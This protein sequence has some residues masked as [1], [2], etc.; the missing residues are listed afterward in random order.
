MFSLAGIIGIILG[1]IGCLFLT[2]IFVERRKDHGA[3]LVNNSFVYSTSLAVY[4]TTWTFYGS[5]GNAAGKGLLYLTIYLG[6]TLAIIFW[7]ST[8]R[9]LV[10][11]KNKY[12]VTSLADFVSAR[13]GKSLG[14]GAIVTTLCLIG[15]IPYISLQLKGFIS[16]F[17]IMT[18]Q[19][20]S[21]QNS[22]TSDPIGPLIVCFMI[23]FTIIFGIRRLDPTERHPGMIMALTVESLLKLAAFVA[24]GVY[25]CFFKFSGPTEIFSKMSTVVAENY[26][27]MGQTTTPNFLTWMSY[28]ILAASAIMFL[29]RQFHV[30]VVEN[31]DE[32]HIKSAMWMF[33]LYLFL[34]NLFVLP[35]AMG[36]LLLGNPAKLADQF[37]LSIPLTSGLTWLTA[38]VFLGGFA[39]GTG[40]VMIETMTVSTMVSNY[41]ILPSLNS[42]K[43]LSFL[44]RHLLKFRWISAALLIITSYAYQRMVGDTYPL[45]AMG[46]I[47]FAAV[48]QFAPAIIGGLFWKKGNKTGAYIGLSS[49]FILWAFTL[50]LP[51]FVKGG[52]LPKSI[53]EQGLFGMSALRPEA[54]LG[55]SGVDSLTHAVFWSMLFNIGGYV[56]GSLFSECSRE[57]QEEADEFVNILNT[58]LDEKELVIGEKNIPCLDKYTRMEALFSQYFNNKESFSAVEKC[59]QNVDIQKEGRMTILQLSDL[60]K[61]AERMLAGSIG[62]AA[63]YQTLRLSGLINES[64]S[65]LLSKA[66]AEM[67]A[68]LKISPKELSQKINFYQERESLLTKQSDELAAV[69]RSLE[70]QVE[71]RTEEL[72]NQMRI[73]HASR[74]LSQF[75]DQLPCLQKAAEHIAR[76][77]DIQSPTVECWLLD[78]QNPV[79]HTSLMHK[80]V[81]SS[82][83]DEMKNLDVGPG[84][85]LDTLQAGKSTLW[86]TSVYIPVIFDG[87][88]MACLLLS[89]FNQ[90]SLHKDVQSFI[91]TMAAT[92][93]SHVSN[94]RFRVE[95]E[96]I[97]R[98]EASREAERA[99]IQAVA[100]SLLPETL[101]FPGM[102]F[103]S[104]FSPA[105]HAGG[106]WFGYHYDEINHRL[107]F[108]LGDVTGHGIPAALISGVICGAIYS[109]EKR[110]DRSKRES[111]ESAEERLLDMA[112]V[113]NDVIRF[114]GRK[115]KLMTMV[116]Q[117][118]DLLTGE[119]VMVSAGHNAPYLVNAK[120][121]LIQTLTGSGNRLGYVENPQFK[122]RKAQLDPGDTMF[123]YSDGLL[124]NTG[125]NGELLREK[126]LKKILSS[127][128]RLEEIKAK[129]LQD[130]EKVWR[131]HS[132]ADDVT[133][134]GYRWNGAITREQVKTLQPNTQVI[135]RDHEAA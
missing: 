125:P 12:R 29:P 40:M 132:A 126:M 47:S 53:L 134:F 66:Y 52:F 89:P 3:G 100:N 11:I 122:V 9:R 8:M 72:R 31:S 41:L 45:L 28:L 113:A 111:F 108:F 51:T 130:A 78:G 95:S 116:F 56:A 55:L 75:R 37:V 81:T 107:Y 19:Q 119:L 114:A 14:L 84:T 59:F 102:E 76:A 46:M 135:H 77:L 70:G 115:E 24:V 1:F 96:G 17:T 33:P 127:E 118:L 2:A 69:N 25:V 128:G 36:G 13:Y 43:R 50:L 104:H 32:K 109:G 71:S 87:N 42:S 34:I 101:H 112:Q 88:P 106:D 133:F 22:W 86:E 80:G 26:A 91:D 16:A 123:L 83:N 20:V 4:C 65:N 58:S 117:S 61:E 54:F 85:V 67:L 79:R 5:V 7:W 94:I 131:G 15:I 30:A 23:C 39:A 103:V 93:A 44:K 105:D 48:L 21:S 124:E 97:A 62:T 121:G 99:A 6:P 82:L 60:H 35:I 57:E 120:N 27:F 129:I 90:G 49:G 10:R 73:L 110:A 38:L 98:T 64:E 92:V 63:A 18:G 74:E 68:S